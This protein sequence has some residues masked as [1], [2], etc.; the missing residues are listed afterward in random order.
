MHGGEHGY[1]QASKQL[2]VVYLI[3]KKL[4]QLILERFEKTLP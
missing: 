4:I 3:A 2:F 1:E